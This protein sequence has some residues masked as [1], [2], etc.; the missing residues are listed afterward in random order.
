MTALPFLLLWA[1]APGLG[2]WL[3]RPIGPRERPLSE[4][5][6]ALFRA[7][8]R[9]TWSYF[10]TFV[11]AEDGWLPPDNYQEAASVSPV[12]RRTSPTN[13]AMY[14][15]SS[16]AAHDLGYLTTRGAHR[17]ARSDA[18]DAREPRAPSRTFPQ[19]V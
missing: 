18:D 8:A 11:T 9:R 5:D 16:V 12:A 14:L 15:L 13:V 4:P 17:A 7:T 1:A 19:L 6:R 3:S 2:Y 10:E